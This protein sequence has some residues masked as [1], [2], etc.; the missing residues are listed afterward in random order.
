MAKKFAF[1]LL[2]DQVLDRVA[3]SLGLRVAYAEMADVGGDT[4][5]EKLFFNAL[6]LNL[7]YC[8]QEWFRGILIANDE[9]ITAIKEMPEARTHLVL[10]RQAQLPGWRV[11]F[12]IHVYADWAREPEGGT[13][14]W[15]QLIVECDGHDF[16]ERTKEQAA[17]DRER[18]RSFQLQGIEVFRF[19]GSELWKDPLG[20]SDQVIAWANRRV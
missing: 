20:C 19:T 6:F 15:K 13:V 8:D 4:P 14:G 7:R 11:D 16:H 10:Q 18:D 1:E 9:S 12:L 2:Q 17:R 5:I 3:Q